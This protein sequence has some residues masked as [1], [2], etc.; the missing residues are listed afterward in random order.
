[1]WSQRFYIN[2][3]LAGGRYVF[4][5]LFAFRVSLLRSLCKARNIQPSCHGSSMAGA[6]RHCLGRDTPPP[7]TI[8]SS[9][10]RSVFAPEI[11]FHEKEAT[12]SRASALTFLDFPS[13]T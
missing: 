2:G 6:H 9:T 8:R 7:A 5:P 4:W 12:F 11:L 1:M 13:F 3:P 10:L